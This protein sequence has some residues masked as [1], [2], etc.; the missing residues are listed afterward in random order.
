MGELHSGH[1]YWIG[2]LNAMFPYKYRAGG[3]KTPWNRRDY[4]Q[5][6]RDYIRLQEA[7][8]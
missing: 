6:G 4:I 2:K 8:L 5:A 3:Q 7:R 1:F